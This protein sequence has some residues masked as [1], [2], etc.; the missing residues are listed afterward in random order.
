[1]PSSWRLW[2]S[3]RF[4]YFWGL[5]LQHPD[6][7]RDPQYAAIQSMYAATT[8]S[9]KAK[10]KPAAAAG[11]KSTAKA[12]ASGESKKKSSKGQQ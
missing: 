2:S 10:A 8:S 11:T 3:T 9:S 6:A 5:F 4:Q 1:L 12:K 7:P